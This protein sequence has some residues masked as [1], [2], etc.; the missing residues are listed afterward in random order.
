M[1]QKLSKLWAGLLF[2]FI[3][4]FLPFYIPQ[5]GYLYIGTEKYYFFFY[6]MCILILPVVFHLCH[7]QKTTGNIYL[8]TDRYFRTMLCIV[9]Y[10]ILFVFH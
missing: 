10:D 8:Q 3:A 2:L 4:I 9:R 6:G 7:C 1:Y 5:T